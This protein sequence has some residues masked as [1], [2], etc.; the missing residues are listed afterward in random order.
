MSDSD[1]QIE[2][3]EIGQLLRAAREASGASVDDVAAILRIRSDHLQAL[4]DED[5]ERLP[6]SVYAIGFI[7]TYATH[8]DLNAAELIDRY[9]AATTLPH[10]E[11]AGYD[12]QVQIEAT[13]NAVKIAV[14]LGAVFVV[15]LMWLI[16]GGARE[17][18]P[19][20]AQ[21]VNQSETST[22]SD[23]SD[24]AAPTP[25]ARPSSPPKQNATPQKQAE[26]APA[27]TQFQQSQQAQAE[28]RAIA[29]ATA[30]AND[31][32]AVL[33][34]ADP[35]ASDPVVEVNAI[36]E[37]KPAAERKI[38]IRANRRTW[39]RI[40]NTE[41]KVLFSSIIRDDES[42]ELEAL[43]PYTLATRDAGALEY[44][45]DGEAVGTVGRRG[46]ILTA[47]EINRDAI[48]ALQP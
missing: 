8:L 41:G 37:I 33:P 2:Q 35:L 27:P 32:Q 19:Q 7:R 42:F 43:S 9:K 30:A 31:T 13:S 25:A 34:E 47:R 6:G 23:Q 1:T 38:E 12:P 48:L 21:V 4:E 22:Q 44:V 26:Q 45:V 11:E 29:K 15:Y 10:L 28:A 36:A 5:F 20:V 17:D 16:A 46:Q 14:V 39:M 24:V 3:A 40:E 18:A